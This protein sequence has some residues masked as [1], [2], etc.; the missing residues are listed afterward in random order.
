M[1]LL[2][3]TQSGPLCFNARHTIMPGQ[4]WYSAD[5][6]TVAR[7]AR[8]TLSPRIATSLEI[9]YALAGGQAVTPHKARAFGNDLCR[10]SAWYLQS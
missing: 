2:Q 9:P 10:A 3:T 4:E 7:W 5:A 1:A 6:P 8:D